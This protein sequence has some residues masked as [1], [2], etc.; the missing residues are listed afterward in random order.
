MTTTGITLRHN[1]LGLLCGAACDGGVCGSG[2]SDVVTGRAGGMGDV[3][4]L[5]LV[6][7]TAGAGG[8]WGCWGLRGTCWAL[9]CA[10]GLGVVRLRLPT[11]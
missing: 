4:L 7:A 5:V 2:G 3:L 9:V 6:L 1:A 8:C 11:L 10:L